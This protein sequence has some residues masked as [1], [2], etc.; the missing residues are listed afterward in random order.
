MSH[1]AF[2]DNYE[3]CKLLVENLRDFDSSDHRFHK[4]PLHHFTRKGYYDLSKFLIERMKEKNPGD[5]FGLIPL[6]IAAREGFF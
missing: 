1:A 6:H 5:C 4:T 2:Y 3:I